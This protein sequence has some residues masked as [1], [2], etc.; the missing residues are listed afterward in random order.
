MMLT[1]STVEPPSPALL[2]AAI[3]LILSS[4]AV[5]FGYI[6]PNYKGT[7]NDGGDYQKYGVLSLQTEKA[8]YLDISSS[9]QRNI[10]KKT[11]LALKKDTI[12]MENTK[13]LERLLPNNVDNV[14]LINEIS[15][16]A[17]KRNLTVKNV[18]VGDMSKTT[19]DTIGPDNTSYGT[20]SMKFTVNSSYPNFL[21][22]LKELE[23]NL[24]LLDVT[25]IS[26]VSTESGFYDFSVSLNT[27]WLK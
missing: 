11:E 13:K 9:S 6:D 3:I 25:N 10:E 23:S 2:A 24:R 20:L 18:T 12:S 14:R 19:T 22:F 5:F 8:N 1:L 21:G 26:F 17:E 4:F 16:I 27:Y 15:K 7:A